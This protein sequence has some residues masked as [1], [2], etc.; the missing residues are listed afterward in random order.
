MKF[1]HLGGSFF[2]KRERLGGIFWEKRLFFGGI[3]CTFAVR[4]D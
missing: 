2:E 1:V 4:K 3:F